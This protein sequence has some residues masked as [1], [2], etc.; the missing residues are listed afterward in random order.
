MAEVGSYGE[1]VVSISKRSRERAHSLFRV[2]A[3]GGVALHKRQDITD[4]G[5]GFVKWRECG[6]FVGW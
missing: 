6:G 1:I 3:Q 2:Y 4:G 5:Q